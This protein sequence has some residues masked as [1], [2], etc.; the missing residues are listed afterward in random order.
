MVELQGFNIQTRFKNYNHFD[1]EVDPIE[2]SEIDALISFPGIC[3]ACI[4]YSSLQIFRLFLRDKF[5]IF[6]YVTYNL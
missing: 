6:D 1:I 4:D 3:T 5:N 2:E